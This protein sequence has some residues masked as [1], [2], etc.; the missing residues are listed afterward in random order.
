MREPEYVAPMT[1]FLAC[2]AAWNINGK[3]FYVAGGRISLAHEETAMRQI[4]KNG[5]WSIDEL[6]DLVP[7][8]LLY[9]MHNPA[10]PPSDLDLPGRRAVPS[11]A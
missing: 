5:M 1:V 10:P 11:P 7:S 3:I 9:G 4:T 6:R 2:D 8:Q